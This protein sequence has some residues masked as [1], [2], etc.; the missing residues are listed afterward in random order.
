MSFDVLLERYA[1]TGIDPLEDWST[2]D[3]AELETLVNA[4]LQDRALRDSGHGSNQ[5]RFGCDCRTCRY[6]RGEAP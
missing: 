3:L 6:I 1:Y 4:E 2:E 5:Y